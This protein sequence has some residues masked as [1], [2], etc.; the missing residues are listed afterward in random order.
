[1]ETDVQEKKEEPPKEEPPK[2]EQ[3]KE[4]QPK[5]EHPKEEAI[6][7]EE[8]NHFGTEHHNTGEEEEDDEYGDMMGPKKPNFEYPPNY[9]EKEIKAQ[10]NYLNYMKY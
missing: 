7:T 8:K 10:T 1:M 5:E 6:H 9:K 3:P 4:E 2:E